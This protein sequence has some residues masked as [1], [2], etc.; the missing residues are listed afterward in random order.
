MMPASSLL[1][2]LG[3]QESMRQPFAGRGQIPSLLLGAGIGVAI[4]AW[5]QSADLEL[6]AAPPAPE[7]PLQPT[8]MS[9]TETPE[10]SQVLLDLEKELERLETASRHIDAQA[11]SLLGPPNE[12]GER[13]LKL[14]KEQS[15]SLI[16]I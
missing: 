8:S 11:T 4:F 7:G 3:G 2:G 16:H 10:F 1:T 6:T 5:S 15:L 14:P 12:A 13:I 9:S